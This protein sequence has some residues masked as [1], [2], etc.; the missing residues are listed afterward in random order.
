MKFVAPGVCVYCRG[1]E[2]RISNRR[3]IA[4]GKWFQW[5]VVEVVLVEDGGE[6]RATKG[7]LSHSTTIVVVEVVMMW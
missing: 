3:M 1:K 7:L 4:G 2:R 6:R 5:A